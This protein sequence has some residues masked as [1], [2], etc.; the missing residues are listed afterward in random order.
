MVQNKK[1]VS[2]IALVLIIGGVVFY[3]VQTRRPYLPPNGQVRD[4]IVAVQDL[5]KTGKCDEAIRQTQAMVKKNSYDVDAWQWKG[6]CEFEQA[7]Y[8]EAKNSFEKVI[9]LD[10]Q[11]AG[12]KT[13]LNILNE[14]SNTVRPAKLT[15]EDFES[16]TALRPAPGTFTFVEANSLPTGDSRT[17]FLQ[18]KYQSSLS[19]QKNVAY[20]KT[21]L[22]E[23]GYEVKSQEQVDNTAVSG[24]KEKTEFTLTIW[25]RSPV[26]IFILYSVAK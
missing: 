25:Q 1:I 23:Q 14:S 21:A 13:Y 9:A 8:A 5:V 6:I 12:A 22:E 17:A 26:E 2:I 19:L 4:E 20:F 15:R 11:R 18:G 10:P 16:Q 24:L 7:N 3:F